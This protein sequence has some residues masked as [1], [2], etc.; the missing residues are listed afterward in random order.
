MRL[1]IVPVIACFLISLIL[2]GFANLSNSTVI[3]NNQTELSIVDNTTDNEDVI[4]EDYNSDS[5]TNVDYI[6][7][8]EITITN[9]I[10]ETSCVIDEI[11]KKY[12]FTP[13]E[14]DM[15]LRIGMCEAGG[16]S[17]ECIAN[18]IVAVLNRVQS[19]EFP[20]NI[21]DVLHQKGQFTP[22]STG[23]FETVKPTEK[24]REALE[25]VVNGWDES[26]GALYF[27]S[28]KGE[29]WHSRNLNF[30]FNCGAMK[31]YK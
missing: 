28:C 16:E 17:V 31:F 3:S 22:V 7:S 6:E 29:S 13:D 8:E 26:M 21:Y 5:T 27:E 23:W 11:E 4:I 15:L 18:V 1:R 12:N 25:L 19:S 10:T 24:C 14:E 30:L 20:N 9:E 2:V